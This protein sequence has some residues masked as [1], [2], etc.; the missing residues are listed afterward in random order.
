MSREI[1]IEVSDETYEQLQ[2]L[3]AERHLPAEQ[4]AQQ[5]LAADLVRARFTEGA[6]AF[7]TEHA[8]GF[9]ARFGTCRPDAA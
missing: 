3:G 7:I 5:V 1:R 6:R 9:A 4:Y 2:R 8:A